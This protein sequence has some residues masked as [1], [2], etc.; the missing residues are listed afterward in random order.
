MGDDSG[1]DGPILLG[2]GLVVDDQQF[3]IEKGVDTALSVSVR[4]HRDFRIV[5][6]SIPI[7]F[8]FGW[9][10]LGR[11]R[12]SGVELESG[13]PITFWKVLSLSDSIVVKGTPWLQ[14]YSITLQANSGRK[15]QGASTYLAA[16][17]DV[18]E[19]K[20][21]WKAEER[22]LG[23]GHL[24]NI[25]SLRHTTPSNILPENLHTICTSLFRNTAIKTYFSLE[26]AQER[27][28]LPS[29]II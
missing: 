26:R 19:S 7:V 22:E 6:E 16:F 12:R 25:G 24:I 9:S 5:G 18:G 15:K 14:T 10:F 11:G 2:L 28:I 13:L 21:N 20:S 29:G 27:I 8:G 17:D 3:S 4:G 23:W 1:V